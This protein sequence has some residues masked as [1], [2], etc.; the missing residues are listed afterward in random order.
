MSPNPAYLLDHQWNLVAWNKPEEE[1]FPLLKTSGKNPNLLRLFLE[2]C[3]LQDFIDDWPMEVERLTRQ[4]R[5]HMAL[6]PSDVLMEL[7]VELRAKHRAFSEL[8]DRHDVAALAPKIRFI[9]HPT[10]TL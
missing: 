10:G 3:E 7:S 4:F 8:W 1:L 6:F 5:A 9:N 2:H